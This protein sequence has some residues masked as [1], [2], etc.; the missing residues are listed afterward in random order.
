MMAPPLLRS[1]CI[2]VARVGRV[3]MFGQYSGRIEVERIERGGKR[4]TAQFGIDR[5]R[6]KC[7]KQTDKNTRGQGPKKG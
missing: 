1:R 2:G 6:R 7:S 3:N 4:T 5:A